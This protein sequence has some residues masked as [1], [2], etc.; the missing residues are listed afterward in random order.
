VQLGAQAQSAFT[1]SGVGDHAQWIVQGWFVAGQA[2]WPDVRMS[3]DDFVRWIEMH[4]AGSGDAASDELRGEE[5]YLTGACIAGDA[6]ALRALDALI[7]SEVER[8]RP[9]RRDADGA[10]EL[11]Q[12]LRGKLL[13]GSAKVRE[14]SGKSSFRR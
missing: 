8:I 3:I 2:R 5:L 13:T 9:R 11:H 6:A 1:R 7:A 14:Y 10:A 4:L 12:V